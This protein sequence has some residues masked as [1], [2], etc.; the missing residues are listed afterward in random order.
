MRGLIIQLR[1]S[2][3]DYSFT[4]RFGFVEQVDERRT[5]ECQRRTDLEGQP[6]CRNT[7][8]PGALRHIWPKLL[9]P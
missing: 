5:S 8:L 3:A 6:A 2:G 7:Q 4:F 9:G 1:Y